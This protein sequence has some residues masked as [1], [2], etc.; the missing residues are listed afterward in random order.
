[1]FRIHLDNSIFYI[2]KITNLRRFFMNCFGSSKFVVSKTITAHKTT[3]FKLTRLNEEYLLL[4]ISHTSF[5]FKV[6]N[7]LTLG[8]VISEKIF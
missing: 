7:H 8:F 3:F 2:L 1:M 6:K 4:R 5:I